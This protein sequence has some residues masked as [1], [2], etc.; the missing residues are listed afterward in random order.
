MAISY[1]GIIGNKERVSLGSAENWKTNNNII[2]DPPKSITT[3]RIDKVNADGSLNEMMYHTSDRLSENLNVFAR[4]VNPMVSVEYGNRNGG[5]VGAPGKMPYRIMNAGA[6]R[7][8]Q[9]R[10]EQLLPLSRQPRNVTIAL[11]NKGLIDYTKTNMCQAT[12]APE[13]YR[14]IK[15]SVKT[16]VAPTKTMSIQTPTKEHFVLNYVNENPLIQNVSSKKVAKSNIQIVNRQ[17]VKEAS[18]EINQIVR[19]SGIKTQGGDNYIH[20]DIELTR[21]IPEYM[22]TTN[23]NIDHHVSIAPDNSYEFEQ[24]TRPKSVIANLTG[25]GNTEMNREVGLRESLRPGGFENR[26]VIP[27]QD[28]TEIYN[29]RHLNGKNE[30]RQR[31]KDGR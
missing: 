6:F 31:M 7:A 1:H 4:G 15:E 30:L 26:G 11:T 19:T 16:F 18:K 17:N 5:S 9:L 8:P 21:N 29:Y 14:Q 22:A 12:K 27:M 3:R 2:K 13:T 10:I 25:N 20:E 23:V 28:R 24:K